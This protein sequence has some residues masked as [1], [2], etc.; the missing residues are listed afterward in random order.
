MALYLVEELECTELA[1]GDGTVESFW[2][3]IKGQTED[4]VMEVYCRPL[5]QDDDTDELFFKE[6]RDTSKSSALAL[7][8]GLQLA[9]C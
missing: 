8:G 1:V 3:R 6:L 4:V 2:V 7:I 9:K 5:S